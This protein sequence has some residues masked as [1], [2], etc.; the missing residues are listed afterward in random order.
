MPESFTLTVPYKGQEL[1]LDAILNVYGY[2]YKI[3]VDVLGA[4]MIFEPDEERNFRAILADPNIKSLP[5]KKLIED[6]VLQL[7]DIF[8]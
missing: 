5:D 7:K 4:E 6:I 2:T 1:N 3:S 8:Q